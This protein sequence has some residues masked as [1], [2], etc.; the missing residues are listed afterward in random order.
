MA[1]LLTGVQIIPVLK[2]VTGF[3]LGHSVT[4]SLATL[5]LVQLPSRLVESA[6]ALS[7]AYVA[8]ED[9]WIR[10][11]DKPRWRIAAAFGLV[12]GFGFA[13]ALSESASRRARATRRG[14]CSGS[15]SASRSARS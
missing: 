5:G 13:K 14:R 9:F 4:L 6:I 12:H 8:A 1:L 3:T 11:A 10:S 2:T 7:I 15:T